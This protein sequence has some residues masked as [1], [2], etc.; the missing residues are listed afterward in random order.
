[1]K[2]FRHT[3][4]GLGSLFAAILMT[5]SDPDLSII[6]ELPLA[7]PFIATVAVLAKIVL[8]AGALHYTRKGLFDYIDMQE[9]FTLA[10]KGNLAAAVSLV[11]LGLIHIAIAILIYA[12]VHM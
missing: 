2:R 10:K 1:M 7:A 8:Y 5:V 4:M 3:F 9:L 11:A 12:C 6:S